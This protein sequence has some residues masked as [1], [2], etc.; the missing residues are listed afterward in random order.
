MF[1]GTSG[2]LEK[3]EKPYPLFRQKSGP[4]SNNSPGRGAPTDS[5]GGGRG[6][7]VRLG[8]KVADEGGGAVGWGRRGWGAGTDGDR[9]RRARGG[10]A[11]AE[12]GLMKT[13]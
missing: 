5:G 1:A 4:V 2:I 7:R 3:T 8:E 10:G 6:G 13:E 11:D 12:K 9:A